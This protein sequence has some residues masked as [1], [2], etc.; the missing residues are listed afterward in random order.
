MS[1]LPP[2]Q[3]HK[4]DKQNK[5]TK[6]SFCFA[7]LFCV[8]FCKKYRSAEVRSTHQLVLGSISDIFMQ[9]LSPGV[10]ISSKTNELYSIN[11]P[12]MPR[13]HSLKQPHNFQSYVLTHFADYIHQQAYT[14]CQTLAIPIDRLTYS[15]FCFRVYVCSMS[16]LSSN[17]LKACLKQA[18]RSSV[19]AFTKPGRQSDLSSNIVANYRAKFPTEAL[20]QATP[21]VILS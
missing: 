17:M 21:A 3:I 7:C 1:V 15:V 11:E 9:I 16:E 6:W 20:W 12:S 8:F 4:K 14:S 13:H 2:G 18:A 10:T 19:E 5:T